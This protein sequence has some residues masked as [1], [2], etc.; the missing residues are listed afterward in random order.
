MDG[1]SGKRVIVTGGASGIG[2]ACVQRF[3]REGARVSLF[4]RD[5]NNGQAVADTLV[6]QGHD[7][8]FQRV[9]VTLESEIR[10]AMDATAER[11]GGIDVL[12]NNA[13]IARPF[14]STEDV[15]E[16][17]W[18]A[19]MAVNLKGAFFATKHA[20]RH[21]RAAGGGSI[22]NMCSICGTKGI[23]GLAP[24]HAAKGAILQMTKNDAV[25]YARDKIRVNSVHPGF[26]WTEMSRDE[27]TEAGG[28]LEAA[29]VAAGSMS[30]MKRM[31]TAEEVANGVVFLASD[32]ASFITGAQ[33]AIDGG[34]AAS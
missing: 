4:D 16:T 6:T 22:V 19:L 32:Q 12:V 27:L 28:D 34:W 31:G 17:E 13:G 29:K 3:A 8:I 14:K 5:E 1:I 20:L 24:Y 15:T 25:D 10:T 23:G 18:D 30:P 21:L 9:D 11:L 33:L 26:I 7:V 2:R